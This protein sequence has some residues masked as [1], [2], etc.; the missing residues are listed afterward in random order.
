MGDC[1]G[2]NQRRE[3]ENSQELNQRNM[4]K[5]FKLALFLKDA[6]LILLFRLG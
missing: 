1:S 3:L 6:F 4:L 5:V 2:G